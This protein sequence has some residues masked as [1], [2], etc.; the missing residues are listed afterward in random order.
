LIR[1]KTHPVLHLQGKYILVLF[2]VFS[3]YVLM[4]Q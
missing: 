4:S 2:T 3:T 1:F